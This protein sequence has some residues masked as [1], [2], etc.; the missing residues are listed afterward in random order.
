MP[1]TTTV[2]ASTPG[3]KRSARRSKSPSSRS[4]FRRLSSG[5]QS[6]RRLS[7]RKKSSSR[8]KIVERSS[9]ASSVKLVPT[10]R[11]ERSSSASSA[12]PTP[13]SD[14][15]HGE[16]PELATSETDAPSPPAVAPVSY[17]L[18]PS[19][20]PASDHPVPAFEEIAAT[21]MIPTKSAESQPLLP[22]S[23]LLND[24]GF[25]EDEDEDYPDGG[26]D[27]DGVTTTLDASSVGVLL[28]FTDD[29]VE[30]EGPPQPHPAHLP[31]FSN[32]MD[33]ILTSTGGKRVVGTGSVG[34]S[35][36]VP[37]TAASSPPE[38]VSG[39]SLP[40]P[41]PSLPALQPPPPPLPSLPNQDG[42]TGADDEGPAGTVELL[43]IAELEKEIAEAQKKVGDERAV[44]KKKER[45]M[46]KVARQ[47]QTNQQEIGERGRNVDEVRALIFRYWK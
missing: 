46:L 9:S 20:L 8:S 5:G 12:K 15:V 33:V 14:P 43:R 11:V 21:E 32:R 4:S 3:Q 29:V 42:A 31:P 30:G 24:D 36:Y 41:G 40:T 37:P 35:S 27:D 19:S 28:E 17:C 26:G 16:V 6:L 34:R 1:L 22:Q 13:A 38:P 10:K 39:Q 45:N 25:D 2:A 23:S 47:M 18:N 7:F 44:R